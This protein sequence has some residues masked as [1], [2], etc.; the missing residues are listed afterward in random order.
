[1]TGAR[2][3]VVHVICTDAFAGAERYVGRLTPLLVERGARVTVIGGATAPMRA[4]VGDEVTLFPAATVREALAALRSLGRGVQLV[5]TH[6]S[7][8]DVAGVLGSG[9]SGV[10]APLVS[11]RHFAAPRG[12]NPLFRRLLKLLGRRIAAQIS[13]SA[14]VADAIGEPSDTVLTGVASVAGRAHRSPH[15][16]LAQRLEKE[17][18]TALALRAWAA[19]DASKNGW[20]MLIAGDGAER[21]T[22]VAAAASYGVA[23][24]VDFLGRR[25]DV[26]ELMAS[27]SLFL[28]SAP[29]EPY[30]LSVAEAMAHG[31]PVIAADGGGH[32]ETVGLVERAALFRPGDAAAAARWIDDLAADEASRNQYGRQLQRAQR[33]YL[34]QAR[35]ADETLAVYERVLGR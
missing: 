21:A 16:L 13:I 5:N 29:A 3:H 18:D 32:R 14:F 9:R 25:A 30:G 17:K 8:A 6:M 10:D 15:V 22:L 23:G 12:S 7:A 2:L 1:M 31:L 20:R 35:W 33:T 27:S 19:T 28:A 11:T 4:L 26:P 34:E 24:S